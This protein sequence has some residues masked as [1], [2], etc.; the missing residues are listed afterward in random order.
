MVELGQ[1][2]FRSQSPFSF[3]RDLNRVFHQAFNFRLPLPGD[4]ATL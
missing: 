2:I 1:S 4:R 3:P